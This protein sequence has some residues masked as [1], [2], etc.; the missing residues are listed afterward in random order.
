M[1]SLSFKDP[2]HYSS[3][4]KIGINDAIISN[5][6]NLITNLLNSI[7]DI[8]FLYLPSFDDKILP[9]LYGI[10]YIQLKTEKLLII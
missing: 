10:I 4:R 1:F 9:G 5:N 8:L 7:S 3:S 6:M 2:S